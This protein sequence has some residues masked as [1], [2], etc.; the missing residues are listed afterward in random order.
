MY[1]YLMNLID[2]AVLVNGPKLVAKVPFWKRLL[3]G[4]GR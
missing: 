4:R 2:P 3:L 1:D